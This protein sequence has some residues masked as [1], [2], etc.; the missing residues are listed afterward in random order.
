MVITK[1]VLKHTIH[2]TLVIMQLEMERE[3]TQMDI[4]GSLEEWMMF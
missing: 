2:F 4:T 1:D 3:E